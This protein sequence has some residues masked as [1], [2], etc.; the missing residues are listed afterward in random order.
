MFTIYNNGSV[1]FRSTVDNLYELK[2][3][4]SPNSVSLKPDDDDLFQE[5]LNSKKQKNEQ[6]SLNIYKKVAN[7]DTSEQIFQ[8]KDIMTIEVEYIDKSLTINEAYE[9]LRNIR[10][11]QIPI[12]DFGKKI[13]GM[14]SKKMILN[15][16]MDDILDI[17]NVL[18]KKIEDLYLDE[19]ITTNPIT[20]IRRVAKVMID[21]KL[22]AIPVVDEDDLLVGIVSKTDIIKAV[23]YIPKLQLWS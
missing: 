21:F 5:F 2:K 12:V 10:V 7:I 15:L 11:N 9:K 14:I 23:S 17:R 3:T 18:N 6:E 20:D 8:V 22:D 1:G 19:I 16:I 13:I 4:E